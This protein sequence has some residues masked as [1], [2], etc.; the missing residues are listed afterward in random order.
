ME[1]Q[2]QEFVAVSAESKSIEVISRG[3]AKKRGL[4]RYFTGKPCKHGHVSER[5]I[6]GACISCVNIN[7][8]TAYHENKEY[9]LRKNKEWMSDNKLARCEYRKEHTKNNRDHRN[10]MT[11]EWHKSNKQQQREYRRE[12]RK[13]NPAHHFIRMSVKRM[14]IAGMRGKSDKAAEILCGYSYGELIN[15]LESQFKDGMS[16][17]NYGYKGWH[18]DHIKPI[19]AFV[20]EGITD[21]K[22][23]NALS[24]LQP[25]WAKDNLSKGAK[26]NA[27]NS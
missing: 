8:K 13:K 23:V 14:V 19:A 16:W 27:Q 6:Y 21:P 22:L 24:N 18:I 4:K 9:F 20:N 26:Y 5:N 10:K 25:L 15:H 17:G 3:E 11:K 7:S 12:Y 2:K 1:Q